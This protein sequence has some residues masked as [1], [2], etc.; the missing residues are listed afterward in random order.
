VADVFVPTIA[1]IEGGAAAHLA[2]VLL[3]RRSDQRLSPHF[4]QHV[5]QR[6]HLFEDTAG[7]ERHAG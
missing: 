5:F 6:L 2:A 4:D 7:A 1:A 3:L